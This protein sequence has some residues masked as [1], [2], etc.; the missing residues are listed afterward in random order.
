MEVIS[1]AIDE[2]MPDPTQPRKTFEAEALERLAES[3]R[4]R[5]ILTPL[6]VLWDAERQKYRIVVGECRWRAARLAKLTHVPCLPVEGDV[7]ETDILSDQIIENSARNSLKP[8]EL[9]RAL[10]KLK[11]L[12]GCTAQQLAKELGISGAEITRTE[13]LL[14]LPH[15]IQDLVDSGAVPEST[16]Y[17]ISRLPDGQTQRELADA[18]AGKRMNRDD[19]EEAVRS[20]VGS[21]N[22]KPKD[23][24]I[25]KKLEGSVT[26]SVSVSTGRTL[27]EDDVNAA[28]AF[29]RKEAK[30]LEKKPMDAGSSSPLAQAS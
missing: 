13:S 2:L 20:A 15:D 14:S 25:S 10:A 7:S 28:I 19:V 16:A 8:L 21:K 3:I 17:V 11:K 12:K 6:R 26:V 24:R 22:V 18:V 9:A 1:V 23:S 30:K 5:G 4:T 27:T 29:L